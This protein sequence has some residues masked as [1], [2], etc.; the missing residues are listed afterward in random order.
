MDDVGLVPR[1][2]MDEAVG[3]KHL[4]LIRPV[5]HVGAEN[6]IRPGHTTSRYS[7]IRPKAASLR[8]SR[9]GAG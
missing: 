9:V 5:Q 3:V 2:L 1:P 6:P 8:C 4:R 7:W